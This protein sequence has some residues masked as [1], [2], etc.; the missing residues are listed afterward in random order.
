MRDRKTMIVPGGCMLWEKSCPMRISSENMLPDCRSMTVLGQAEGYTI[1]F[2]DSNRKEVSIMYPYI[3]GDANYVVTG[4]SMG[5]KAFRL[6]PP[7][8]LLISIPNDLLRMMVKNLNQI[9]LTLPIFLPD[10]QEFR[11]NQLNK[12]GLDPTH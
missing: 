6:F 5:M 9:P 8:W 4:L 11:R 3:T 10:G 1:R 2:R 12:L 7:G